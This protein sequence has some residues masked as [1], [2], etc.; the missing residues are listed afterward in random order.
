M[1]IIIAAG[2]VSQGHKAYNSLEVHGA[3][4]IGMTETMGL[5]PEVIN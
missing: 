2:L 4:P 5:E 3:S 1:W